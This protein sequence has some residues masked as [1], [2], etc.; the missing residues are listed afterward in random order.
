EHLRKFGIPVVAD[1]P[2]GD[3]LQDHVGTASLNF[4]AKDAEPLLLRQVTNPF[5]LREFVK[6]GTGPLTSF[7]GIEGMAYVN[8]KYQNPKLDWPDLEIHLASGSPASD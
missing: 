5:N 4:E 1:L 6:N 2:V 3:N 7:S 8:S